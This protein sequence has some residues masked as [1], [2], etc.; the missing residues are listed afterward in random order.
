M[1]DQL[2]QYLMRITTKRVELKP[3]FEQVKSAEPLLKAYTKSEYDHLKY[4]A[5]GKSLKEYFRRWQILVIE[6]QTKGNR[7]FATDEEDPPSA[8]HHTLQPIHPVTAVFRAKLV[9]SH[10]NAERP[11]RLVDEVL[12]W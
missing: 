9:N 7:I 3:L 12:A 8:I 11:V 2:R 5:Y 6:C 1:G 4:T 10:V